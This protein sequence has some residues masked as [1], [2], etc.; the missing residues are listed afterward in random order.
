MSKR[1]EILELSLEKKKAKLD[2]AF[3]THFTDVKRANGQPLNDKRCGDS[4]FRRWD[5]QN[6]SIRKAQEEIQKT[7]D[8][9][10]REKGK[11]AEVEHALN[12]FPKPITDLIDEGVLVVWRKHP[13]TLFVQGVDKAR[14]Q[15]K[16]GVLTHKY[17]SSIKCKEQWVIFRDTFNGLKKDI[18]RQDK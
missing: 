14:I 11:I 17:L 7:A 8:A 10:E 4:T 6:D 9:I 12:V 2:H 13:N 1:L 15:Y 3:N 18:E 16:D 5:K